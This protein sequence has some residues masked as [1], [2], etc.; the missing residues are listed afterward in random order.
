[1]TYVERALEK[2]GVTA[3]DEPDA[4]QHDEAVRRTVAASLDQLSPE[5]R[6]RFQDL[7]IIPE[8][9]A[10]P[11]TTLQRLWGLDDLET[12]D[13]ARRLDDVA[14]VTL[15]LHRG[16]VTLHDAMRAYVRA[17][18]KDLPQVHARLVA[19]DGDL[20]QLPDAYAW[21]WIA[22]HLME[23]GQRDALRRLLLTPTWL[24][25]KLRAVGPYDLLRDFS[26]IPGDRDVEMVHGALRLSLAALAADVSQLCEQMWGR[27]PRG[28][29]EHMDAFRTSLNRLAPTRRLHARWANLQGPTGALMQRPIS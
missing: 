1:V 25:A 2:R 15:D 10:I 28:I 19:G 26:W 13:S 17:Q 23:A 21:R 29:S 4:T 5:D 27:L 3:F 24:E 12:D 11:L 7:T 22:H 20:Q 16:V 9:T 18:R 6:S 8:E 14:V